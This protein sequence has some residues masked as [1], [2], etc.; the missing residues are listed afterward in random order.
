MQV[1]YI[2]SCM[3]AVLFTTLYCSK[4]TS[5]YLLEHMMNADAV[6]NSY[7]ILVHL[8]GF[9]IFQVCAKHTRY[10]IDR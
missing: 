8:V 2:H 3:L 10:C 1:A 5:K 7:I 4:V 9:A 6:C